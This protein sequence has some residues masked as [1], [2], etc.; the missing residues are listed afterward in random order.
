M[1]A[2]E[3]SSS[4]VHDRMPVNFVEVKDSEQREH[5]DYRR[6]CFVAVAG[7]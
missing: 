4:Q 7:G 3:P 5:G 1:V 6:R 2:I